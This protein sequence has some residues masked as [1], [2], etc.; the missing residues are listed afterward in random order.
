MNSHLFRIGQV[1]ILFSML[2]FV[3]RQ[4][5]SVQTVTFNDIMYAGDY[6]VVQFTN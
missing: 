2:L 1:Y 4:T 6:V 5:H 3:K